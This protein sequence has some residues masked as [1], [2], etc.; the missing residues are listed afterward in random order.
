MI[1]FSKVNRLK[2]KLKNIIDD[3]FTKQGRCFHAATQ[4]LF[5][6]SLVAFRIKTF[7]DNS[8]QIPKIL[9]Y[10]E[11][12]FVIVL[13]TEYVLRIYFADK[14]F[15]YIFNF[16]K[17]IDLLAVLPFYPKSLFDFRT[18]RAFRIF[19]P[20]RYNNSLRRSRITK[21]QIKREL[22]LCL[23]LTFIFL[24]LASAGIY[25]FEHEAQ[26]EYFSS[27][28]D[29][30]WWAAVTLTLTTISNV[31]VYP[32]IT[33]GKIFTLFILLIGVGIITIPTGLIASALS[34][35][36]KIQEDSLKKAE[37]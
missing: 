32:I 34:K 9:Y 17:V 4:F 8:V 23:M 20:I 12:F 22:V 26:P 13:G 10:T 30:G 7:P 19:K 24:F 2:Q 37:V 28:L 21:T 31:D 33:S 36:R 16:Y 18:L 3:N 25:Y 35:A 14:P 15:K 6:S 29:S 11:Y 5:I 27:V 1:W